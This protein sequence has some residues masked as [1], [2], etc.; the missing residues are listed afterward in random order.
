MKTR[1]IKSKA[2][3]FER[4]IFLLLLAVF[5]LAWYFRP[6]TYYQ[7][8]WRGLE[9]PNFT[10]FHYFGYYGPTCGLTRSFVNLA[11]GRIVDGFFSNFMGPVVFAF[12]L[13][14]FCYFGYRSFGG[15]KRLKLDLSLK[16]QRFLIILVIAMFL[17]SWLVRLASP[18][19]SLI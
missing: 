7:A 6:L 14:L 1:F 13:F 15:K 16:Q 4:L 9:L 12:F 2:N 19:K 5:S 10:V 17:I 8:D 18:L 3:F 11:H